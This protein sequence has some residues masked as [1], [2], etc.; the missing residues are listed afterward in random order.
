M[1]KSK[2]LEFKKKYNFALRV[3]SKRVRV[4]K[5]FQNLINYQISHKTYLK[6]TFQM[7]P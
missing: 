7:K 4:L 5:L 6:F 2:S 3:S 1:P